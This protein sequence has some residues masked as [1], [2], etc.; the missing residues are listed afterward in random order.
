MRAKL[1][2]FLTQRHE[3]TKKK[4]KNLTTSLFLLAA[5]ATALNCGDAQSQAEMTM[6]AARDY[7]VADKELNK[8]WP[9]T[10]AVMKEKDRYPQPAYDKGPSYSAALLASQRAWLAY[11]DAQCLADGYSARGGTMQPMLVY[12]CKARLTDE[13]VGQ[14]KA[15]A[16]VN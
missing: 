14:L 12:G 1:G 4:G 15:M 10:L 3:G 2:N 7:Q 6:C 16:D 8:Q 5:A 11:R 13:R 9:K